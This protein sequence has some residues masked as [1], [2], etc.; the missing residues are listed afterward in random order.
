MQGVFA[1]RTPAY[2]ET[3]AYTGLDPS[4]AYKAFLLPRPPGISP[5]HPPPPLYLAFDRWLAML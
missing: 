1:Q 2:T 5:Q 3:G 4:R